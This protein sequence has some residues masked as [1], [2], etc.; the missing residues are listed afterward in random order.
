M[1]P[2]LLFIFIFLTTAARSQFVEKVFLI[3]S[4][5]TYI[6]WVIEQKPQD[7]I[8]L[9]RRKERDTIQIDMEKIWKIVRVIDTA[10]THNP[11][12]SKVSGDSMAAA[13]RF[14]RNDLYVEVGGMGGFGTINYE[15]QLTKEPGPGIR[16]GAGFYSE[17][18]FYLTV[19]VGI[20]YLFSLKRKTAFIDAGLDVTWFRFD[21]KLFSS[22]HVVNEDH[23]VS[24]IPNVGYRKHT[25]KNLMWRASLTPVINK[26]TFIPWL[27]IAV[28]KR[29]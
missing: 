23:F 15:R 19:P 9:L 4:S 7:Y 26:Y 24:F 11:F 29:F 28:G 18:G 8:R 20:N 16:I 22:S 17:K 21:A 13:N 2:I 27:G 1:K 25:R 14:R 12:F 6:G 10:N 3:D 5:T